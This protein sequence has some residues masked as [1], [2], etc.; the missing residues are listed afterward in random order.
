M[1]VEKCTP[2][3]NRTFRG[4]N[5]VYELANFDLLCDVLVWMYERSCRRYIV[6]RATVAEPGPVQPH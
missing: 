3:T 2:L 1:N 6:I 4:S 5:G